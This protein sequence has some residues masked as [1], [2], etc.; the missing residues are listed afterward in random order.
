VLFH[1]R[2]ISF[3]RPRLLFLWIWALYMACSRAGV[4]LIG[5]NS[6]SDMFVPVQDV[7]VSGS[8][9]SIA[10]SGSSE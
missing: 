3:V 9:E 7:L 6:G 8:D 4:M 5:W 10:F 2:S 1:S